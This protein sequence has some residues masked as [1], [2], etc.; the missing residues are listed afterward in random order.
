MIHATTVSSIGF[1]QFSVVPFTGTRMFRIAIIGDNIVQVYKEFTYDEIRGFL[2]VINAMEPN[3]KYVPMLSITDMVLAKKEAE[4][5]EREEERKHREAMGIP[6]K[7]YNS[8]AAAL[9]AAG[10]NLEE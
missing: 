3:G 2:K 5:R 8:I 1:E 4:E 9:I 10:W 6:S 7:G